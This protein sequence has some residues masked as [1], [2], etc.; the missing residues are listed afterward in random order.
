[1]SW[2]AKAKNFR[3]I[4]RQRETER[5]TKEQEERKLSEQREKEFARVV[6]MLSPRV[7][8]V[9]KVFVHGIKGKLRSNN[10]LLGI[11]SWDYELWGD[12]DKFSE[13]PPSKFAILGPKDEYGI[14]HKIII[15]IGTDGVSVSTRDFTDPFFERLSPVAYSEPPPPL[16][17][18]RQRQSVKLTDGDEWWWAACYFMPV[19]EF[20]EDKLGDALEVL[21]KEIISEKVTIFRDKHY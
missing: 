17:F 5:K 20:T 2:K 11:L 12:Y 13:F 6:K 18:F 3:D 14:R 21:C 7:K 9:C 1:M 19:D 10:S 8:G 4:L 15:E 16:S